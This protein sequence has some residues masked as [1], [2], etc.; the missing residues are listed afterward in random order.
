M[1]NLSMDVETFSSVDLNKC[2]VYRYCASQDFEILLFG[3]SVDHGPVRTIDLASGEKIPEE[4]LRS[5]PDRCIRIPMVE[6]ERSLNLSNAVAI[7]LYEALR[8]V[9]Y[10]GME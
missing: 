9:G 6:G 10:A 3:Y 4:I 1:K 5:A 2:G 7:A 8:Q